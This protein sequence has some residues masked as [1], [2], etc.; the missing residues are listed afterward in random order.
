MRRDINLEGTIAGADF[1]LRVVYEH[2]P[3]QP[4]S[5]DCAPAGESVDIIEM[6]FVS[7]SGEGELTLNPDQ[8]DAILETCKEAIEEACFED[9]AEV[10]RADGWRYNSFYRAWEQR[11]RMRRTA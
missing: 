2:D 3:G 8:H 11:P 5:F 4:W 9:A 7:K 1:T 10:L 6:G